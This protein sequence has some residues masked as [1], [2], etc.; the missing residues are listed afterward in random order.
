MMKATSRILLTLAAVLAIAAN[1]W[2]TPVTFTPD[3]SG[4]SVTVTDY[5]QFGDI[6][7]ALVL[8]GDSFN[9]ADNATQTLDFFTLTA[10]R[11]ALVGYYNVE[12]TLA[13][14][15]PL[16]VSQ[17]HG[18]GFFFTILGIFS[19]AALVWDN[20]TVP[21]YFT[22]ADGNKIKIDFENTG[23]FGVGDT[24][25]VHANVTNLGNVAAVPEPATMLLL[26]F[27][28]M[29]IAGVRRKYKQ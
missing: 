27:S 9:L 2:A 28:L 25:T 1:V 18:D 11:I 10:S 26:G 13:F 16:I 15:T 12:A 21:D 6:T 24:M 3:V 23:A 17:G 5:A 20:T 14:S 7:G 19:T 4:S 29:G 8:S 22:L